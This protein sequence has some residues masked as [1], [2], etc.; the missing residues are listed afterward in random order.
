[1]EQVVELK[2]QRAEEAVSA[3]EQIM[4]LSLDLLPQVGGGVVSTRL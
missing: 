1:M 3:E 2:G 4:E